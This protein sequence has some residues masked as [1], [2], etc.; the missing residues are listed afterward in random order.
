MK[1][2]KKVLACDKYLHI[3]GLDDANLETQRSGPTT[4]VVKETEEHYKIENWVEVGDEHND[5]KV[6]LS[7]SE[8]FKHKKKEK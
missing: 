4:N 8:T 1:N 2:L 6:E 5:E 7:D 3:L